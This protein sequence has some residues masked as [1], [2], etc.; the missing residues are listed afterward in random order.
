MLSF[1][2]ITEGITDQIVIERLVSIIL[3]RES[4]LEVEI[5]R[6][7]PLCDESDRSRQAEDAFGGFEN[8]LQ[9]CADTAKITEALEFNHYLIIQVDTDRCEHPKFGL[10]LNKGGQE[11]GTKELISDAK[12]S[13]IEKITLEF[14]SKHKD[15]IIFGVS[16]HST[17]CWLLPFFSSREVDR[18]R[19]MSCE[20]H[21]NRALN[22]SN[23]AYIKNA[24]GYNK[25]CSGLKKP[26]DIRR[27]ASL[28]E[29]LND[30][31]FTLDSFQPFD[32]EL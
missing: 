22:V 12:K 15:R 11:I 24:T 20:T 14:Y 16:V 30:F 7:Q 21:L 3:E 26:N 23:T 18:D 29:S 19:K 1:A 27:A 28:N 13:L 8:L 17:E 4:G 6:L 2:L 9:Y 32:F 31:I 5:N 10:S 25:L